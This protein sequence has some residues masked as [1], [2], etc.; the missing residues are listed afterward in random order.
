MA[1]HRGM[2]P[3][4]VTVDL[5]FALGSLFKAAKYRSSAQ[6]FAVAKCK[7]IE[8]GFQ[9]TDL[10]RSQSIRSIQ[11]GMGP[12]APKLDIFFDNVR[13]DLAESLSSAYN[14]LEV[15]IP[16]RVKEPYVTALTAV[17]FLLRGIEI[18]NVFGSDVKFNKANRSV[19]VRL[20]VSKT[21]TEGKGCERTHVCICSPRH[22]PSCSASTPASL[23]F[24][25]LQKCS[26]TEGRRPLCVFYALLDL[27]VRRRRAGSYDPEAPLFGEDGVPPSAKQLT[28]LAQVYAF[29]LHNESLHDWSPAAID[30][31]SQHCFR[32]SGSQLFARSGVA[33]PVIQVIGRWGSLAVWRYVQESVFNPTQTASLVRLS[34]QADASSSEQPALVTAGF[35]EAAVSALVRRVVA[36]CWQNKATD[37]G[38]PPEDQVRSQAL[39]E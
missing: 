17:W 14:E 11:K 32:V 6:Y 10:A 19:T 7:H 8:A 2:E 31:W 39:R 25:S 23:M 34:G 35:D 30:E 27:V 5:L 20:P 15:P 1:A 38:A 33:L 13:L 29:V 26:C 36:E 24:T 4:P 16:T 18:A 22:R 9:W 12:A 21:D 28:K 37:S 3:L